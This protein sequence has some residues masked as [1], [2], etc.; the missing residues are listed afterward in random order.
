M[1]WWLF[2]A[3]IAVSGWI[4]TNGAGHFYYQYLCDLAAPYG[5]DPPEALIDRMNSF[6]TY[7]ESVLYLGWYYS[8]LYSLPMLLIYAS[9]RFLRR[10]S[11]PEIA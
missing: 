4:F 7:Q 6:L 10:T 1:P 5:D 11:P 2:P 8:L 3:V 9:L